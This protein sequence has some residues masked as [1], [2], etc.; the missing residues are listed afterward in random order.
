MPTNSSGIFSLLTGMALGASGA[1]ALIYYYDPFSMTKK[2]ANLSEEASR[3]VGSSTYAKTHAQQLSGTF[4]TDLL[5][6]LW[7]QIAHAAALKIRATMEPMFPELLPGPVQSLKFTKVSLGDVPL[8]LDNIV[9]HELQTNADGIEYVEYE[10]D[11]VWDGQMDMQLKADYIGSF[12]VKQIKLQGRMS[13]LLQ[14]LSDTTLPCFTC[15]QYGF[16][17]MP[18]LEMDFTGLAQAADFAGIRESIRGMMLQVMAGMMVLPNRKVYKM[19]YGV[20]YF[21]TYAPPLGVARLQLIQGRGFQTE[22]RGLLSDDIPDCYC[23]IKLGANSPVWKTSVVK[24]SLNPVWEDEICDF[25]VFHYDQIVEVQT[26]DEDTGIADADDPLG[27]AMISVGELL[28]AGGTQEVE[29]LLPNGKSTG[30]FVTLNCQVQPLV[31]DL[32]SIV[33]EPTA[34]PNDKI[35]KGLLTVLVS[36][37]FDVP[38]KNATSSHFVKVTCG[39]ADFCTGAVVGESQPL[40]ECEFR[41]PITQ[42]TIAGNSVDGDDSPLPPISFALI[43]G[44][45]GGTEKT[46]RTLGTFQIPPSVL[47]VDSPDGT[48]TGRGKFGDAKDAAS[49]EYC[50]SLRGLPPF[51]VKKRSG[52]SVIAAVADA[53][54]SLTE[55]STTEASLPPQLRASA[56]KSQDTRMVKITV[57]RGW[58]FQLERRSFG[59]SDIPDVYCKIKFGSSPAVWRTATVKDSVEPTWNESQVFTMRKQGQALQIDVFDED[60]GE[61]D[62]DDYLGSARMSVGK[63]LLAG[64]SSEIELTIQEKPTGLFLEI[65]C[66]LVSEDS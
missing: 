4:L 48:Q 41:I 42:S 51:D 23:L 31:P 54:P 53:L 50:V 26:W 43:E 52:N 20:N 63:L 13:I 7:K 5:A 58:G 46:N 55:M 8:K 3:R 38:V 59:R 44:V 65:A 33:V 61:H 15:A 49:L 40:Y 11:V 14:P 30:A 60:R 39:N 32:S 9:V 24:D 66:E 35:L 19:D 36:Q 34:E 45:V 56:S 21:Q 25:L 37:A 29:L 28:L 18:F 1:A 57:V 17:N 47:L 12:G 2:S 6:A 64:G 27:E 22:K 16:I 62:T 10:M